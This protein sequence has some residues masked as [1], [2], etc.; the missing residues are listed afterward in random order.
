MRVIRPRLGRPGEL[1][2]GESRLRLVLDTEGVDLGARRPRDGELG[3]GMMEDA[4]ELRWFARLH[5]EGHDVLD[6]E[7]D[8]VA[9][10]DRVLEAVLL[11][12]DRRALEPQVLSHQRPQ[13]LHRA[14]QRPREHRTELLGL[15]V[16]G[17]LVDDDAEAPVAL[18]HHLRR[19]ADG[20]HRQAAHVRA[21]HLAALDVEDQ[22]DVAAVLGGAERQR[23]GARTDNVA[24]AGLEIRAVEVPG[25]LGLLGKESDHA[26]LYST[27]LRRVN[28]RRRTV[29]SSPSRVRSRGAPPRLAL[30][31]F[32]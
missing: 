24:R 22:G 19:V 15:L 30:A 5:P 13:G 29:P 7:V 17:R 20:G 27:G 14:P 2:R 25:H 10:A 16:G 32:V 4:G 9:D 11:Y 6:L 18:A 3:A 23:R 28:R 1:R 31:L 26:R 12:L 21:L 8:G